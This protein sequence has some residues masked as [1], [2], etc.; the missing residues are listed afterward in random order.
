MNIEG[1]IAQVMPEIADTIRQEREKLAGRHSWYEN[2]ERTHEIM[3]RVGHQVAQAL[4]NAEGT[5]QEGPSRRCQECGG[6]QSYHD[7][8]HAHTSVGA[9]RF[10][11]RA[12]YRCPICH[13]SSYPLDERLGLR[14]VGRT[15]RYLQEMIGWVIAEESMATAQA[16]IEKFWGIP[17]ALSQVRRVGEALGQELEQQ[18]MARVKQSVQETAHLEEGTPI[19]QPPTCERLYAAPDGWMYCTTERDA[20]GK[21][22]WKEAKTVA[23]Y[24]ARPGEESADAART[25]ERTT[26][27]RITASL[28]P[29][30]RPQDQPYQLSYVV[31]AQGTWQEAGSWFWAELHERGA[32]RRLLMWP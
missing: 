4:A 20:Q 15:S 27:Q 32:G 9:I 14:H 6:E 12:A 30:V 22:V 19:R 24:E 7:Q 31:R 17:V 23:I 13:A 11:Q 21:L 3:R 2:E 5:G 26:R 16:T 28:P 8:H 1:L 25:E 29:P 10:A 18:Q